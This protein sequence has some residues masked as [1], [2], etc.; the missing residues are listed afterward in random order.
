[1]SLGEVNNNEEMR[2]NNA[3]RNGCRVRGNKTLLLSSGPYQAAASIFR[4]KVF[5]PRWAR[6]Q[7]NMGNGTA[8]T[9]YFVHCNCLYRPSLFMH[10]MPT[11]KSEWQLM[12]LVT[13]CTTALVPCLGG[14]LL[15]RRWLHLAC[16]NG[17]AGLVWLLLS[18]ST[19][20]ESARL[21]KEIGKAERQFAETVQTGYNDARNETMRMTNER[22]EARKKMEELFAK[23]GRGRLVRGSVVGGGGGAMGRTADANN[24]CDSRD[25]SDASGMCKGLDVAEHARNEEANRLRSLHKEVHEVQERI[26]AMEAKEKAKGNALKRNAVKLEEHNKQLGGWHCS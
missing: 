23:Q 24:G 16:A 11:T 26:L 9:P 25:E 22:E 7:S 6:E 21:N 13:E 4:C 20:K 3:K 19:T 14:F 5:K 8:P 10:M 17:H 18:R 1:M 12:Y 2:V 15:S